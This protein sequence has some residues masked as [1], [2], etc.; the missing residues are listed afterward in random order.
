MCA[1]QVIQT[2]CWVKNQFIWQTSWSSTK[3]LEI[4]IVFLI[5]TSSQDLETGN[6]WNQRN[7][8]FRNVTYVYEYLA[9][10]FFADIHFTGRDGYITYLW[11][12]VF[13]F[14]VWII[15]LSTREMLIPR[16]PN[17]ILILIGDLVY[18]FIG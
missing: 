3:G 12:I 10:L 9:E 7:Q 8:D 17:F 18:L 4:N 5:Q 16:L 2:N 15:H 6:T 13:H 1:F 11:N 14:H